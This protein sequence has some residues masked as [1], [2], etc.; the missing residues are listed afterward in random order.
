MNDRQRN[1][2]LQ[3]LGLEQ[4]PPGQM[5]RRAGR[6]SCWDLTGREVAPMVQAGWLQVG[7]LVGEYVVT[8]AGAEMAGVADL[9]DW[10]N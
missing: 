10:D 9:V 1:I 7:E 6:N 3:A 5:P 4:F 2:I 8:K